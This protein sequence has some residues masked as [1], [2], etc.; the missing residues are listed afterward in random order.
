MVGTGDFINS[1]LEYKNFLNR[2]VEAARESKNLKEARTSEQ[3][4][5]KFSERRNQAIPDR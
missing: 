3:V 5:I 4:E 1:K 2:K